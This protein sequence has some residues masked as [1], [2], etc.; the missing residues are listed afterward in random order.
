MPTCSILTVELL[1][2]SRLPSVYPISRRKS[3]IHGCQDAVEIVSYCS[4]PACSGGW[5]AGT[6]AK[7]DGSAL[8]ILSGITKWGIC[9]PPPCEPCRKTP[10]WKQH[11]GSDRFRQE[12]KKPDRED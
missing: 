8:E 6:C 2:L 10:A 12:M 9:R 4:L 5:G 3:R 7:R 11:M 1:R